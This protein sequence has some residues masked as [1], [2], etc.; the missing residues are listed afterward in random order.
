MTKSHKN[1][2]IDLLRG[3]WGG[4]CL[5]GGRGVWGVKGAS[6]KTDWVM[7]GRRIRKYEYE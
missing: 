4:G 1:T 3:C 5:G 7:V 2:L 6:R